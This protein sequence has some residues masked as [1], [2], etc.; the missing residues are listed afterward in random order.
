MSMGGNYQKTPMATSLT[1]RTRREIESALQ[2]TGKA[3]PASIVSLAGSGIATIKFELTNIPFTLPTVELPIAGSE[4]TRVP[5]QQ[6]TKGLV[7]PADTRIGHI[8]GLGG[9]SADLSK[10]GNLAALTFFPIGNTGWTAP[11]D[12]NQLELYGVDGALIKSTVNKEWF[13]QWTKNGATISNKDG[14]VSF[15]LTSAGTEIKGPVIFDNVVTMKQGLQ[16][17]GNIVAPGG[18][19]Y[20]GDILTSGDV[21]SGAG[22]ADAVRLRSHTHTSFNPGSQT[23]SPTAGT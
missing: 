10:P 12:A 3:L 18:G 11:E 14:S 23:S 2:L 1:R 21:Q 4:F 15:S 13:A 7:F 17:A 8:S 16:L 22:G 5:L 6:G 19:T 20:T 9:T